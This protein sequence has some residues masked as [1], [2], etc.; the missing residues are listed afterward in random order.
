METIACT[1]R[2]EDQDISY[3]E[4]LAEI[5]RSEGYEADPIA[6]VDSEILDGHHRY[7][8]ALLAGVE[9]EVVSITGEKYDELLE[10]GYDDVEIAAAIH[11]ANGNYDAANN[12][13]IKFG[14]IVRDR[15][16]EAAELIS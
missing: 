7:E 16:E 15:A 14:G 5:F 3:V 11:E 12:I 2:E 6:V 10:A 1:K 8:A 13:D 4:E 9:V